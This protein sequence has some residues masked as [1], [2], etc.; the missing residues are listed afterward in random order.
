MDVHLKVCS[1]L[2]AVTIMVK[3]SAI[4]QMMMHRHFS[5]FYRT[6]LYGVFPRTNSVLLMSSVVS[7]SKRLNV[8]G[9]LWN[10]V[11]DCV[12]RLH[13]LLGDPPFWWLKM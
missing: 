1:V 2:E 3:I 4:N 7:I 8:L 9:P 10:R 5:Y 13:C 11:C 6:T 12:V